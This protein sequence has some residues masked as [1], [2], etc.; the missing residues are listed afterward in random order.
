MVLQT[1]YSFEP[2]VFPGELKHL[3]KMK[4]SKQ[5]TL[6]SQTNVGKA[7]SEKEQFAVLNA[8]QE[9]QLR[10]ERAC[11]ISQVTVCREE[12]SGQKREAGTN[13]DGG[14]MLAGLLRVFGFL[15]YNPGPPGKN[16]G[17]ELKRSPWKNMLISFL[18][19]PS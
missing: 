5:N 11:F 2:L 17:Q 1:F 4:T 16:S 18:L 12:E 14:T 8:S 10:E 15:I 3:K 6:D 7:Y 13:A 9:Q 19:L